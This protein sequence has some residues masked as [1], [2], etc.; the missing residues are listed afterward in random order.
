M[1]RV[2]IMWIGVV[3][4]SISFEEPWSPATIVSDLAAHP[5]NFPEPRSLN[6]WSEAQFQRNLSSRPSRRLVALREASR[7][8]SVRVCKTG[9]GS[10]C[11]KACQRLKKPWIDFRSLF[12]SGHLPVS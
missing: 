5:P 3:K 6:Y 10:L 9:R 11:G 8:Q 12:R 4:V 1:K 7:A 2:K